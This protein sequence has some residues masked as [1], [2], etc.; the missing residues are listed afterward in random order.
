MPLPFSSR[1]EYLSLGPAVQPKDRV[2]RQ[3]HTS[4]E[5]PAGGRL[6]LKQFMA[7]TKR[8]WDSQPAT[9]RVCR[10]GG[11]RRSGGAFTL[12]ELL[13]VIAVIAILAVLLMPALAAAQ[14]KSKRT[15]SEERR[16]GKE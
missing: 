3:T 16:V 12:M 7:Q 10:A 1:P 14:A 4:Q 13:L 11:T 9:L 2:C 5:G 15:R 8:V 6:R